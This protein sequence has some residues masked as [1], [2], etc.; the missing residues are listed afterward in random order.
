MK[1]TVIALSIA[2]AYGGLS[3]ASCVIGVPGLVRWRWLS[4]HCD[5]SAADMWTDFI[6]FGDT[7]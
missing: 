6:K 2:A 1:K 4:E 5:T 7:P 3:Q